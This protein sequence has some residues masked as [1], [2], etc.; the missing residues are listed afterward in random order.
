[1]IDILFEDRG[2]IRRD[3]KRTDINTQ[4]TYA[5]TIADGPRQYRGRK[6]VADAEIHVEEHDQEQFQIRSGPSAK[7]MKQQKFNDERDDDKKCYDGDFT[8]NYCRMT[9][10]SSTCDK[11]TNGFM[12]HSMDG[13]CGS[14]MIRTTSPINNPS[15]K[16]VLSLEVMTLSPTLICASELMNRMRQI[17]PC[18]E[19]VTRPI[20]REPWMSAATLNCGSVKRT[21]LEFPSLTSAIFP[22]TPR[23]L[24][25]GIP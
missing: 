13:S 4:S 14:P 9:R 7:E 2:H 22:T 12:M 1:M 3:D 19:P 15:G 6:A 11:T 5:E 21:T 25:T 20:S 8:H 24:M 18:R 16:E 17:S 10:T 23:A